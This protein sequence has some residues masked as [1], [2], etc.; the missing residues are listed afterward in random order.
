MPSNIFANTGTNVSVVFIDKLN[1]DNKVVLVDASKLGTDIKTDGKNQRTVLSP[2]EEQ[3]II[4]TFN[5]IEAIDDFSV[6]VTYDEIKDKNYS[7]SAGQYF[8]IKIPHVDI[9]E[10]EFNEQ[11]SLSFK[12]L[13]DL[14]NKSQ[15]LSSQIAHS[16]RD[17]HYGQ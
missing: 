4:D 15:M 7:L 13:T 6:T 16:L 17:L 3:K 12:Y 10:E 5:N 9:T 11:V 14:T 2:E 8:D 1:T